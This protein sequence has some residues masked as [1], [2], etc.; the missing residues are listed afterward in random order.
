MQ[1]Q[2]GDFP[3]SFPCKQ[4]NHLFPCFH[5]HLPAQLARGMRRRM[6][7]Q[8]PTAREQGVNVSV[9]AWRGVAVPRGTPAATVAALETAIRKTVETQDFERACEKLGIRPAFLPSS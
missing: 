9:E 3:C 5:Q 8:I 2:N 1:P 4:G 6:D 7:V